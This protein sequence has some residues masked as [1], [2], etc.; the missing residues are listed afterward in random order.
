MSFSFS[1]EVLAIK[2]ISLANS[3]KIHGIFT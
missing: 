3:P 2:N 1:K